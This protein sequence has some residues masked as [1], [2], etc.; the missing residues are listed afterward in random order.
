MKTN[1]VGKILL[2]AARAV[3]ISLP[4][5]AVIALAWI[6]GYTLAAIYYAFLGGWERLTED[7]IYPWS[8]SDEG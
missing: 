1:T 6:A 8:K 7:A 5:A 2:Y 3:T 4:L